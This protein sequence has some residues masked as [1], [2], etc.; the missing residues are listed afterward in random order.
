MPGIA[1]ARVY[2]PVEDDADVSFSFG[3]NAAQP[4][5]APFRVPKGVDADTTVKIGGFTKIPSK[6]FGGGMARELKPSAALI[7]L[8]LC[9]HANRNSSNSFKVSDR[10][11]SSETTFASGTI[12]DARKKLVENGL[13]TC[14]RAEGQSHSYTLTDPKLKWVPLADRPRV[15]LRP[16]G[17]V[18]KIE[19]VG[20][21]A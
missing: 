8:A 11:I 5:P 6:F 17:R 7:Y 3:A 15:K 12:C 14:T 1:P 16:R 13:I 10:A 2:F 21:K 9:E 20:L 4:S 19:R 18:S